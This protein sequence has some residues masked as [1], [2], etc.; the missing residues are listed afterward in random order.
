MTDIT[1]WREYLA[2]PTISPRI[3]PW[4]AFIITQLGIMAEQ[5]GI[6]MTTQDQIN[7]DVATVA[8]A[9]QRISANQVTFA[10]DL[11]T[12]IADIENQAP[13]TDLTGLDALAATATNT[14]S[15]LAPLVAQLDA[16]VN[17]TPVTP[18]AAG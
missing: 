4:E 10:N 3:S 2:L 14:A 12:A 17:S 11:T 7:A 5:L 9:L 6:I 18:P 1:R 15:A 13:A 16:A 8:A